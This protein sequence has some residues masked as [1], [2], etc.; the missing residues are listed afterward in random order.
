MTDR[1]TLDWESLAPA[2]LEQVELALDRWET[3]TRE[4]ASPA[5]DDVCENPKLAPFVAERIRDLD[6]VTEFFEGPGVACTQPVQIG[7]IR[8]VHTISRG[9]IC[10][11]YQGQQHDP[12]RTVA[13]KVL[14][15]AGSDASIERAFKREVQILAKL[16]HVGVAKVFYAAATNDIQRPSLYFV[17]E[18]VAG[19]RLT[20][21]ARA[22]SLDLS[23]RVELFVKVCEAIAHA[24][25]SGVIH[26]DLKPSNI[27]CTR[28]G[29]PKILDFGIS[30]WL[31]QSGTQYSQRGIGTPP[32][33]SPEQFGENDRQDTRSDLYSLGVILYRLLSGRFPYRKSVDTLA[34][35]AKAVTSGELIPLQTCLKGCPRDLAAITHK[36]LQL[37]PKN[38]YQSA[39]LLAADL[40]AFL[41]GAP[42]EARVMS[43][44]ERFQRWTVRH[45]AF[46][47]VCVFAMVCVLTGGIASFLL[48]RQAADIAANLSATVSQLQVSRA[49]A[50]EARETLSDEV[51]LRR[52]SS[53]NHVLAQVDRHWHS[54]PDQVRNWLQDLESKRLG[55]R[56]FAWNV[57]WHRS[58]RDTFEIAA[59]EGSLTHVACFPD[60]QKVVSLGVDG[61]VRVWQLASQ[62][63]LWE[64]RLDGFGPYSSC[65][66]SAA[67]EHV[68]VATPNEIVLY[69]GDDG[70]VLKRHVASDLKYRAAYFSPR[71]DKVVSWNSGG[72]IQVWD[73]GLAKI[74]HRF[75]MVGDLTHAQ[76]NLDSTE[77]VGFVRGGTITR[78]PLQGK[79]LAETFRV[80]RPKIFRATATNDFRRFA[81]SHIFNNGRIYAPGE[82]DHPVHMSLQGS[83]IR[84]MRFTQNGD[85][86]LLADRARVD[87]YWRKSGWEMRWSR[88]FSKP[89]H[90]NIAISRDGT[91]FAVGLDGGSLVYTAINAERLQ[92]TLGVE[93]NRPRAV[94][95]DP[96]A[97]KVYVAGAGVTEFVVDG[98]TK[99]RR[100]I[101][102]IDCADAI[103]SSS[104]D[105]F[106][107]LGKSKQVLWKC[108]DEAGWRDALK[109]NAAVR[110]VAYDELNNTLIAGDFQGTLY[111]WDLGRDCEMTTFTA[112]QSPVVS[113]A[114]DRSSGLIATGSDD[115]EIAIW[116]PS[117]R[118]IKR[119]R[120]HQGAVT[121]IAFC[122]AGNCLVSVSNDG[123]IGIIDVAAQKARPNIRIHRERL[124]AVTI[125]PDGETIASAGED[126]Q[127]TLCDLVTG[128]LQAVLIGHTETVTALQFSADGRELYSVAQDGTIRRWR[129]RVNEVPQDADEAVQTVAAANT[130]D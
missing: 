124:R 75:E 61:F 24:H 60:G 97:G 6:R 106:V 46:A 72:E 77:V 34:E 36:C 93:L 99:R 20:E 8:I 98:T 120:I 1:T 3:A 126:R 121:D 114:C 30:A 18:Y 116:N 125:S 111:Q 43:R 16:N 38:R 52:R 10:D 78:F 62:Q 21:Y 73:E 123:T 4:N 65:D 35:A 56:S 101:L 37:D 42:V 107:A 44:W 92:T 26:R 91:H 45:R 67:G 96:S 22:K 76:I 63:M 40:R 55:P 84:S 127:I 64:R 47:A 7:R 17:M 32:Y 104:G 68:V 28:D 58:V 48:W 110:T 19:P 27:L 83:K 29:Q 74:E 119:F 82:T 87:A 39:E 89:I 9:A 31:E 12:Q 33:M 69:R 79:D 54:S 90:S 100:S 13:V 130:L 112:H 49:E 115:G 25:H 11:V 23:Q 15:S 118:S 5:P 14:H 102:D 70:Q 88:K 117:G 2:E 109:T 85:S 122:G 86:L 108:A 59:H 66:V 71:G 128:E 103:C 94:C 53:H 113:L 95:L 81:V 105:L 80:E 57:Q 50:E 51:T 41:A 129:P